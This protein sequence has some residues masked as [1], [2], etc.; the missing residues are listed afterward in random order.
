VWRRKPVDP[1]QVDAMVGELM[2]H[3]APDGTQPNHDDIGPTF[4]PSLRDI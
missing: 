4:H 1:D 2:K 3:G